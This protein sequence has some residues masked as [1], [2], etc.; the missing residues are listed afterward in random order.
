MPQKLSSQVI[1]TQLA[2]VLAKHPSVVVAYIFGSYASGGVGPLSDLDL[3][4]YLDYN[5]VPEQKARQE[6]I[7]DIRD[8]LVRALK[9]GENLDLICLNDATPF[10]LHE[11]VYK[12]KII[13]NVDDGVR[14]HFE[15]QAMGKWLDW[16]W[17]DDQFNQAIL[18]NINRPILDIC[19]IKQLFSN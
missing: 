12:G 1:K 6:M 2:T 8:E 7:A 10:L 19:Q 17:Y 4:V 18:E 16:K 11:I 15:A 13:Y 14:A 9:I 5:Q 3:A